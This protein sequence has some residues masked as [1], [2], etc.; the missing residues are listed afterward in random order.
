M[1]GGLD[2]ELWQWIPYRATTPDEMLGY[3]KNALKDQAAGTAQ[4]L[5]R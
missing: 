5:L 4:P 2:P 3:I 1:R